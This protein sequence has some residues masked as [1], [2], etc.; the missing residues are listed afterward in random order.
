MLRA[1]GVLKLVGRLPLFTARLRRSLGLGM[2]Q[3][4][5]HRLQDALAK[6]LQKAEPKAAIE[7]AGIA[8]EKT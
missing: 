4:W 5:L 1:L 7:R 8:I 6:S 3:G 2:R